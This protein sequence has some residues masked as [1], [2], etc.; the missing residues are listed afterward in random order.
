MDS[1]FIFAFDKG[2]A[3]R[4]KAYLLEIVCGQWRGLRAY[5]ATVVRKYARLVSFLLNPALGERFLDQTGFTAC[6]AQYIVDIG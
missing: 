2:A 1:S 3:Y 5:R 4:N 6:F